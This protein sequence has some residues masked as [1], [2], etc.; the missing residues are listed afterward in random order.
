MEIINSKK[1]LKFLT[2]IN[3]HLGKPLSIPEL[4]ELSQDWIQACH[5]W[6][7]TPERFKKA[8]DY[9][10]SSCHF[11][12]K[13]PDFLKA[14]D[15]TWSQNQGHLKA[16]EDQSGG[17]LFS[18]EQAVLNKKGVEFLTQVVE[19]KISLGEALSHFPV[20]LSDQEQ[21]Y[22]SDSFQ[23]SNHI[24]KGK[25]YVPTS[26]SPEDILG[27]EEGLFRRHFELW[28]K[29]ESQPGQIHRSFSEQELSRIGEINKQLLDN[30]YRVAGISTS[31][32]LEWS[33]VSELHARL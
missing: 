23:P 26:K 11:F 30:G 16:I 22:D 20:S 4:M 31:D 24:F 19:G 1:V 32:Q 7:V 12:P 29:Y 28:Q 3:L 17:I 25:P 14:L 2:R 13:L 27:N 15:E 18:E 6:K 5:D 8:S 21:D 33:L 9:L 10:V